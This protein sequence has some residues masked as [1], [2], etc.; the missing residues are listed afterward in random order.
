MTIEPLEMEV[1]RKLNFEKPENFKELIKELKT[2][3]ISQLTQM[4][5]KLIHLPDASIHEYLKENADVPLKRLS[6]IT[7]LTTMQKTNNEA[8]SVSCLVIATESGEILILDSYSF[9]VLHRSKVC[10]FKGTPSLISASGQFD[11]DFRIVVATREGSICLLRKSWLEGR[12]ILKIENPATGLVILPIDQTI[13]VVCMN[14]LLMCYSKK[15]KKLWSVTLP[16]PSVCMAPVV[17]A[18]LGITLV[19]VALRGGLVQLYS[20]KNLVDQFTAPDTISAMTFGRL[21]QEEHVLVLVTVDGSLIVKILKRTADFSSNSILGKSSNS[22]IDSVE[23]LQIPKK[24]KIFVE[25]T[26]RER[27]NARSIHESFQT[28]LWRLRLTAARATVDTINSA[29]STISGDIGQAPIKLAAEIQGLGPVFRLKIILE[30]MATRKE[31]MGLSVLLHADHRHYLLEKPYTKL[32]SLTP[33]SPLKLDFK[34]TVILDKNDGLPPSDLTPE[35]AIIRVMIVKTGQVF[36]KNW[37]ACSYAN[38]LLSNFRP[39]H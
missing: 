32:P 9:T 36:K 17:L 24:T 16:G 6:V 21:G 39:N 29:E 37:F 38:F 26:N 20:Q 25:Q 4:S 31:A 30:N 12:Q 3:E 11:I 27:E 8:K 19:C 14:N 7:A 33:S 10:S 35:T 13:V 22:T 2:L 15:G 5:Q 28:E 34:V 18:H 1:W 23:S